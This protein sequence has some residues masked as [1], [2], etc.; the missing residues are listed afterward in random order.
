M[1]SGLVR[2]TLMVSSEKLGSLRKT[3]V[4][5]S[6]SIRK[7]LVVESGFIRKTLV[8]KKNFDGSRSCVRKTLAV[9][10]LCEVQ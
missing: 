10:H 5:V 4:V 6:G 2:K 3:L 1:V 9:A 8:S 7:T